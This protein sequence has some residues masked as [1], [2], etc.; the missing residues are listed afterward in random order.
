MTPAMRWMLFPVLLA[1]AACSR[2]EPAPPP[3][4]EPPG[5]AECRAEARASPEYRDL[6]RS[7]APLQAG[8]QLGRD[9]RETEARLIRECLQRRGLMRPG[10]APVQP[11]R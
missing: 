8:V 3:E 6:F 5:T 11:I 9:L 4:P 1:L 10:V 7:F 2:G